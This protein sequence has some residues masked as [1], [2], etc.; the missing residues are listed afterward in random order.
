MI[1]LSFE[2]WVSQSRPYSFE[3]HHEQHQIH[4]R[5]RFA[6]R[7]WPHRL[8]PNNA[9]RL[10][11]RCPRVLQRIQ[12]GFCGQLQKDHWQRPQD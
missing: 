11:R 7:F 10:L 2:G 8:R 4:R 1:R 12:L 5:S 9:E 6:G 3:T